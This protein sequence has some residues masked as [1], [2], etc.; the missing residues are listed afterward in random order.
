M[1]E[2]SDE[3]STMLPNELSIREFSIKDTVYVLTLLDA[4]MHSKQ[5]LAKPYL[6]RWKIEVDVRTIKTQI[7]MEMLHCQSAERVNK[8]IAVH[9]LAYNLIRATVV[10][11]EGG[12][13]RQISF[14]T[15][16]QLFLS[17]NITITHPDKEAFT[18]C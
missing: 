8:E 12:V 10:R 18:A 5:S 3:A 4:T 1:A 15:T 11:A 14:M 16:V 13:L 7:G 17:K 2:M 6:Q 9:L